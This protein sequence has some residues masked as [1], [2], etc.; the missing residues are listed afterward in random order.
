MSKNSTP[1]WVEF[2]S[3]GE[4]TSTREVACQQAPQSRLTCVGSHVMPH[5][6]DGLAAKPPKKGSPKEGRRQSALNKK[7]GKT[8]A[9][10]LS[11]PCFRLSTQQRGLDHPSAGN[12][13][14]TI[15]YRRGFGAGYASYNLAR[16]EKNSPCTAE[17]LRE[18]TRVERVEQRNARPEERDRLFASGYSC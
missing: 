6:T 5:A 16:Q 18:A 14:L 15:F 11:R 1:V 9:A 8:P 4:T 7:L 12:P 13:C 2:S 3:L 17:N 10:R